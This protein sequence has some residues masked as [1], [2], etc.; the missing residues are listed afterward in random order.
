[1]NGVV[2]VIGILDQF[3]VDSSNLAALQSLVCERYR[4][5]AQSRGLAFV[6]SWLSPPLALTDAPNTLWVLWEVPDVDALWAM[7]LRAG[8]DP[9]TRSYWSAVDDLCRKRQRHYLI[10]SQPAASLPRPLPLK[11][12]RITTAQGARITAQLFIQPGCSAPMRRA[13]EEGVK[14]MLGRIVGL[15]KISLVQNLEG[16]FGAGD[17]TFDAH[18]L[19]ENSL[20]LGRK[21]MEWAAVF[22]PDSDAILKRTILLEAKLISGGLRRP[23]LRNAIKRTAYFRLL[24][25]ASAAAVAALERATLDMPLYMAGMV[26]WSLSRAVGDEWTYIWEQEYA[27]LDDLVGEYMSHPHHWSHVDTW[28][29]P[30]FA[31]QIV[32]TTLVHAFCPV[33]DSVLAWGLDPA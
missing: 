2:G 27:R 23:T 9:E 6:R 8:A 22:T 7:R 24:P 20:L 21:T 25:S 14:S 19:D 5:A 1:M 13:W 10:D 3:D 33:P 28:F 18:F 17:Y 4:P 12:K 32:D 29:D 30:E 15:G 11:T 26:N 16:S 31:W